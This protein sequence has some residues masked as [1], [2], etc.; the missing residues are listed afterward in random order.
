MTLTVLLLILLC[1]LTALGVGAGVLALLLRVPAW[2]AP[3][4]GA[5]SAM[6]L[7]VGVMGLLV[8]VTRG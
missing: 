8:A 7:M 4:A 3:V 2:S 6:M 1:V 5:L